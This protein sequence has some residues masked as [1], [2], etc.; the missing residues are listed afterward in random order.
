MKNSLIQKIRI[1]SVCIVITL[2]MTAF[3]VCPVLAGAV[4]IDEEWKY[5]SIS[6]GE[7]SSSDLIMGGMRFYSE[8]TVFETTPS[9]EN[10]NHIY[11]SYSGA[12][13]DSMRTFAGGRACIGA[14]K[15]FCYNR[16]G[17]SSVQ[18]F[19]YFDLTKSFTTDDASLTVEIE[20]LDNSTGSFALRYVNGE[21]DGSFGTVNVT[22][23]GTGEW[24]KEIIRLSDAYFNK[25][26]STRLADGKCDFRIER[27]TFG[28]ILYVR[29]VAVYTGEDEHTGRSYKNA[30]IKGA[31]TQRAYFTA[32]MWSADSRSLMVYNSNDG[33]VYRFNVA[34]DTFTPIVKTRSTAFYVTPNNYMYY[35][36][37]TEKDLKRIHIDTLVIEK[38]ADMY[39]GSTG[40]PANIHVNNDDTKLS[41]QI[42]ETDSDGNAEPYYRRIPMLDIESG[43][44]DLNCTHEFEEEYPLLGHV[45]MNPE[46]DNLVF[47]CHEGTTTEIPDRLWTMDFETGEAKNVFVQQDNSLP[48]DNIVRTGETSGHEEWASDGEHL[49]F[50]K[51]PRPYNVGMNGIVRIDKYGE[52]REYINDDYEYWHCFPSDDNRFVVADCMMTNG[53]YCDEL[54]MNV[55]NCKIALTDIKTSRSHLLADIPAGGT[56]PYQPHPCISPDGKLVCFSLRA[57]DN[58]LNFGIMDVSDIADGT[59]TETFEA[60]TNEHRGFEIS[61]PVVADGAI[62]ITLTGTRKT[63]NE[64]M[65]FGVTEEN[66]II[67]NISLEKGNISAGEKKSLTVPGDKYYIW[68]EGLRPVRLIPG[69]PEKLRFTAMFAGNVRLMWFPPANLNDDNIT[70]E[71]YRNGEY[72]DTVSDGYYCDAAAV[73]GAGYTYSVRAVYPGGTVSPFSEVYGKVCNPYIELKGNKTEGYGLDFVLNNSNTA[74]DS[75]TEYAEI[76]GRE[77]RKSTLQVVDNGTTVKNKTGMFYFAMKDDTLRWGNEFTITAEYFD[78]GT[79]PIYLQYSATDGSV[80]KSVLLANRT[81]SNKWCSATVAI[82]DAAFERL[83]ELTYSDFRINGGADTYIYSVNVV[84]GRKGPVSQC[85]EWKNGEEKGMTLCFEDGNSVLFDAAQGYA[86]LGSG[87]KL[88]CGIDDSF[89][90]AD[91]RRGV[92]LELEYIDSGAGNIYLC[93]G[94]NDVTHTGDKASKT[95]RIAQLTD[96]GAVSKK[97]FFFVDGYFRNLQGHG[98]DFNISS[99][100]GLKIRSIKIRHGA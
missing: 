66:G 50:V 16:G 73:N 90:Y 88:L 22:G 36:D 25:S 17:G 89:M 14:P 48:E 54:S 45:I 87:E 44:W 5:A 96:S 61:D 18:G 29:H 19:L 77:C 33:Y 11:A 74:P 67:K 23:S 64:Y 31:D 6:F 27:G 83:R 68:S 92:T 91:C 79:A 84:S 58:N 76:G 65:V 4:G 8:C 15:H 1:T 60:Y 72:L 81:N 38:I 34:D 30:S 75:Y 78:N 49:A 47:F 37:R 85:S 42:Y 2:I 28:N 80:A 3:S 63:D 57:S 24:K 43:K 9:D 100:Y 21:A 39:P 62:S 86:E 55:G 13:S 69:A 53:A 20:Y 7:D 40:T 95:V 12:D 51:Y 82:D 98:A 97:E 52:Q 35:F 94:T 70:Y 10:Q 59:M 26:G 99:D 93:H 41:L 56:H 46:Y 32:R 71:V